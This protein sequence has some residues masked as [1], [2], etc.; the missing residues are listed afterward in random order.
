[1]LC[2]CKGT[3]CNNSKI[4]LDSQVKRPPTISFVES[5]IERYGLGISEWFQSQFLQE[6]LHR[7][8][9]LHQLN[10]PLARVV[11]LKLPRPP[12][13]A[14][15]SSPFIL[16]FPSPFCVHVLI[17]PLGCRPVQSTHTQ[18]GW[19]LLEKHKGMSLS[20]GLSGAEFHIT[21]LAAFSLALPLRSVCSFLW[22]FSEVPSRRSS[23][24]MALLGLGLGL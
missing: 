19:G 21:V 5:G 6:I 16:V 10:H 12:F 9:W 7:R 20:M 15:F 2:Q 17:L 8:T 4:K 3:I 18:S 1:M 24:A 23:S 13:P 11:R 22:A 14:L